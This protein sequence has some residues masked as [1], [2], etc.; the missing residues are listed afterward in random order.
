MMAGPSTRRR[1]GPCRWAPYWA[2]SEVGPRPKQRVSEALHR[3]L[4]RLGIVV[5]ASAAACQSSF[6]PPAPAE[7]GPAGARASHPEAGTPPFPIPLWFGGTINHGLAFADGA[8]VAGAK[9]LVLDP[10]LPG[11]YAAAYH[12][13]DGLAT[14]ITYDGTVVLYQE[15]WGRLREVARRAVPAGETLRPGR[16][17]RVPGLV[18]V[19]NIDVAYQRWRHLYFDPNVQVGDASHLERVA[20]TASAEPWEAITTFTG[21]EEVIRAP[22]R[23]PLLEGLYRTEPGAL[24]LSLEP[25]RWKR[26]TLPFPIDEP[27]IRLWDGTRQAVFSLG[28]QGIVCKMIDGWSAYRAD[29][30]LLGWASTEGT[31]DGEWD[32]PRFKVDPIS[33]HGAF[34]LY[35]STGPSGE[36]Y[37]LDLEHQKLV[38]THPR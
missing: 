20:L 33:K 35:V 34:F 3:T 4:A 30:T 32:V 13:K 15:R 1:A 19:T 29:G 36:T 37:R 9:R 10:P 2:R 16:L 22:D 28:E 21:F 5:F 14:A 27:N 18:Y 12:E 26:L 31:P 25:G 23:E 17:T 11:L 8:L 38:S 6:K 24:W 7:G